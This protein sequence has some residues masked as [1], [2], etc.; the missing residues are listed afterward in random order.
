MAKRDYYEILGVAKT[1]SDAE[2]KRAYRAKAK[3][4]HPDHNPDDPAA[5]NRIARGR[6]Q[7]K[8]DD[9]HEK[10]VRSRSEDFKAWCDSGLKDQGGRDQNHKRQP[11]HGV[12]PRSAFSCGPRRRQRRRKRSGPIHFKDVQNR[13]GRRN[14]HA[15][16]PRFL[17]HFRKRGQGVGLPYRP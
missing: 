5:K 13:P 14:L 17:K 1:A 3:K 10:P 6:I 2:L 7:T 8:E 16:I 15:R 11:S 9:D 12:L 4:Y